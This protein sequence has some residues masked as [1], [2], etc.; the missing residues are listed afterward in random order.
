MGKSNLREKSWAF[1]TGTSSIINEI[2]FDRSISVGGGFTAS[3]FGFAGNPRSITF[4]LLNVVVNIKN[5]SIKKLRSTI[6]VMSTLVL[7]FLERTLPPFS[8]FLV[9]VLLPFLYYLLVSWL[10]INQNL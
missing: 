1:Y 6:G 3:G 2:E 10:V 4:G 9:L 7:C 8:P 5:I